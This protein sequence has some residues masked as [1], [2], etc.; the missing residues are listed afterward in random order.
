[1]EKNKVCLQFL[2][3]LHSVGE[4]KRLNFTWL[5]GGSVGTVSATLL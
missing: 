5:E 2:R 4:K 3:I 1:M